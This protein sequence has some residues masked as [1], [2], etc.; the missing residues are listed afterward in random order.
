MNVAVRQILTVD[1]FLAWADAQSET[2]R[3]ELINGQIVHMSPELLAHNRIKLNVV[4]AL[5]DAIRAAGIDAEAFT[6]G[7]AVPIDRFTAYEP[8]ALVRCG[9]RLPDDELKAV[10]PIIVVEVLS[11][12]SAH[13]DTSAKLVGYFKLASVRH[14]LIID[15][16]ARTVTHHARTGDRV[17]AQ[18]L[19]AGSLHLNPPG[20]MLEVAKLFG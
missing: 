15:S 9:D 2:P 18:T 12:T 10:D 7:I 19:T 4:I 8:D 3:C 6:D 16:N 14:Y 11:P 20:L 13:S 17:V 1:D 5:R